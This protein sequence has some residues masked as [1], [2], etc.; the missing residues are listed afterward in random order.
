MIKNKE[1]ELISGL[2]KS[3]I[4]I[5]DNLDL[6]KGMAEGLFGGL[7]EAGT[8]DS[9]K[10]VYKKVLEHF[11]EETILNNTKEDG[12]E[13]HLMAKESNIFKMDKDM[14][15][16]LNKISL[17]DKVYFIRMTRLCMEYGET[18]S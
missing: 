12:K 11:L 8:K 1:E 7:M 16:N 4:I 5:R 6:E 15:A 13:E 10:K 9:L 18:M 2:D 14:K 3:K 17:M